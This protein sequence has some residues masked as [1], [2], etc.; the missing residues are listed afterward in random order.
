MAR[1][2]GL[3]GDRRLELVHFNRALAQLTGDNEMNPP[4]G[5]DG[6]VVAAFAFPESYNVELKNGE[7]KYLPSPITPLNWAKA[8]L[9]LAFDQLMQSVQRS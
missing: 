2:Y 6:K 4:L 5:A 1:C 8:S 9:L 7:R 3:L